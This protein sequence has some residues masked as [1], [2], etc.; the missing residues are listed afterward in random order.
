MSFW[1]VWLVRPMGVNWPANCTHSPQ[2]T[3]TL[4]RLDELDDA[5]VI[6]FVLRVPKLAVSSRVKAILRPQAGDRT[7]I[8]PAPFDVGYRSTLLFEHAH[9]VVG[10][11]AAVNPWSH[12][13]L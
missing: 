12:G 2:P 9:D 7:G 1:I 3:N 5:P 10:Q 13:I 4:V 8:T 6:A 11:A